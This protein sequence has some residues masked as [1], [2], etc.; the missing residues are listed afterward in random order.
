[1]K[2]LFKAMADF[3]S[4][5]EAVAKD[6]KGYGYNYMNIDSL[7]DAIKQPLQDSKLG[8]YH[9]IEGYDMKVTL[10]HTESGESISASASMPVEACQYQTVIVNKGGR[11]VEK[12][13]IVGFEGMNV[14]Q[15]LGSLYTYYRRYTLASILGIATED[16][17]GAG[18]EPKQDY[19]PKPKANNSKKWLNPSTEAWSNFV[20]KVRSGDITLDEG[21]KYYQVSKEN[22]TKLLKECG[23][24]A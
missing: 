19:K 3:Q 11:D 7:I 16:N 6:S 20:S 5:I 17:D 4:R 12:T 8:F 23:I 9:T 1:M 15:A 21:L 2:N 22:K 14:A 10:Y 24:E 13:V 18:K